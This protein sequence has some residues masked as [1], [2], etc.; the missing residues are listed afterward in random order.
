MILFPEGK[1]TKHESFTEYL[2]VGG[3]KNIDI[4]P[5]DILK[6]V[7]DAGLRGRGGAGF[8]TGRKWSIAAEVPNTPRY[9][10]CNAGE[11]EPGSF[12]DRVL[13]E[14]RP[15]LVLEGIVL[16]ARAIQA[17]AAFLYLNETYQTCHERFSQ[18]I[19]EATAAGYLNGVKVTI[20]RAP[21]VYVAG[22]DTAVIE[23][24]E[25]KPPKPRQ[26]PPY[27]AVAGLFG[28]PTIVNNVE[29][30]ANVPPIV[31]HGA[32]WFRQYGTEQS[33][34]TML[35]CLGDEIN[36]PG[37]YE[38]PLGTPIRHLYEDVGGKLK[39]HGRLKAIL[40]GGPSCGFF[41]AEALATPL[42]PDSCKKAGSTLGCGVM[43]FYPQT[44][45][46][47]EETLKL[48]RFFAQESCGQCPACRME[49]NMLVTMLERVQHGNGDP[50]LFDQCQ[51]VLDFNRGK[52]YCALI[53][54]PG[55]PVMSAIRLFRTDFEYH[56]QHGR[57]PS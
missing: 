14:Y 54:M 5:A 38:L 8:P 45:C 53:N 41:T 55:P 3:Y 31:R 42:D 46:M 52:G 27:P 57:C 1:P 40:P 16:A 23:V 24:L 4:N 30:L 35:F 17:E 12:K 15:H 20:H 21:T 9:V 49:T 48:A 26:K 18:A 51:K 36:N 32:E 29:T 37:V 43:R 34:G 28:K 47:V 2:A 7:T 19:Q 10:V 22:E 11:D 56:L 50:G 6:A 13:I 33:P 39:N 44:A 25:G